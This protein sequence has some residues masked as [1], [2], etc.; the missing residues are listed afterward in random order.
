MNKAVYKVECRCEACNHLIIES[1]RVFDLHG[2]REARYLF[3]INTLLFPCRICGMYGLPTVSKKTS[4]K[5][6]ELLKTGER[7]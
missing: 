5:K 4:N 1:N 2:M 6:W 7:D 3:V